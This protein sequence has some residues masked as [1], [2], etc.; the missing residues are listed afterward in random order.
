MPHE[1]HTDV[2]SPHAPLRATWP[3]RTADDWQAIREKVRLSGTRWSTDDN[4]AASALRV[5]MAPAEPAAPPAGRIT[6]LLQALDR[7]I[8]AWEQLPE[9]IQTRVYVGVGATSVALFLYLLF[10]V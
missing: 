4:P 10:T 7:A 9:R 1:T 6:A 2:T 8:T 5:R 3:E